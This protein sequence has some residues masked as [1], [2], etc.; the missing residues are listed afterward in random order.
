MAAGAYRIEAVAPGYR[1]RTVEGRATVASEP[2][3]ELRVALE[4]IDTLELEV[5]VRDSRGAPVPGVSIE[6]GQEGDTATYFGEVF[7]TDPAGRVRFSHV[8]AGRSYT[9]WARHPGYRFF[10]RR[11]GVLGPGDALVEIDL[12]PSS[13]EAIDVS[14][15]VLATDG[16]PAPGARVAL[17]GLGG[18]QRRRVTGTE[19]LDGGPGFEDARV[20]HTLQGL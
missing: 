19:T 7:D 15:R 5:L 4:K 9:V 20:C 17:E 14:G 10:D 18:N 1:S 8:P 12:M 11:L 6:L 13:R 16:S 3:V 2:A